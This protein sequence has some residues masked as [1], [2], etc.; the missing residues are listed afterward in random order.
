MNF[1]IE[2]ISQ[3]DLEDIYTIE[4]LCFGIEAFS[5][6]YYAYLLSL[7]Y[8]IGFKAIIDNKIVGF[9]LGDIKEGVV[10]TLNVHP[11]FRRIGIATALMKRLFEE[12][13]KKGCKKA[14]IQ[15]R[16][17]N[18]PAINLYKKLGFSFSSIIKNY[19]AV[20]IHAYEMIKNLE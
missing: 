12:F 11:S 16:V 8:I 9:V 2:K 17:D 13:I 6:G 1:L 3:T 4:K 14:V 20:G 18:I 7:S 10:I 15:V 19:Y 5:K